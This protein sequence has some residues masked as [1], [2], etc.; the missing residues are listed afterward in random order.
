MLAF[1]TARRRIG[2][3]AVAIA[4]CFG[5][6]GVALAP[7][8]HA[9]TVVPAVGQP[10][11]ITLS[12]SECGVM[13]LGTTG[14]CIVSLQTWMNWSIGSHLTIDGI[15]GQATLQ[16]VEQ[17]QRERVKNVLPDGHFGDYSRAALRSWYADASENGTKAPCEQDSGMNCDPGSVDPG[18]GTGIIGAA[19]CA[20]GGAAVG[21]ATAEILAPATAVSCEVIMG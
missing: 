19:A 5:A 14:T 2:A 11:T 8:A 13:Y 15:Y 10:Y 21:A 6:T 17:F 3:G 1:P 16:A 7:Q 12:M 9:D 18:L 20:L 4:A